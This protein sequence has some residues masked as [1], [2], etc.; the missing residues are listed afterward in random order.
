MCFTEQKESC[1]KSSKVLSSVNAIDETLLTSK[2]GVS[3]VTFGTDSV[4]PLRD[5]SVLDNDFVDGNNSLPLKTQ[6]F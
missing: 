4:I 1:S 6:H 3:G 2:H 5:E